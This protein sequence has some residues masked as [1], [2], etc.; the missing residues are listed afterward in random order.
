MAGRRNADTDIRIR[1]LC[2]K[3]LRPERWRR[4][5]DTVRTRRS[6]L[7]R[8]VDCPRKRKLLDRAGGNHRIDGL[9]GV[10]PSSFP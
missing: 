8:W 9:A 6:K 10:L 7:S 4:S 3:D 1:T 2:A 5:V